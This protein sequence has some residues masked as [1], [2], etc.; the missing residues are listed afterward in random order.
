MKKTLVSLSASAVLAAGLMLGQTTT[1]DP[2]TQQ[3]QHHFEHGP[4]AMFQSL[5]LTDAQK[6]QAKAIF[7]SARESNHAVEQQMRDARQALNAAAKS[8]ATDAQIDQLAAKIG[9]L[10]AQLAAAQAK[11]FAKFYAILTPEQRTQVGDQAFAGRGA[12]MNNGV[13]HRRENA[14]SGWRQSNPQAGSQQ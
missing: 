2:N 5:N 4:G 9:P 10:S 13:S 1:G 8:G 6:E 12:G 3:R 14:A 11:T 7:S